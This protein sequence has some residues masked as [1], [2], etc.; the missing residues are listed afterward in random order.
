MGPCYGCVL[1]YLL[2]AR[3]SSQHGTDRSFTIF[4]RSINY[5]QQNLDGEWQVEC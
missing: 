5:K 2:K 4:E 1:N 3:R